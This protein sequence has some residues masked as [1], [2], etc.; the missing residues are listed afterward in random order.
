M[1]HIADNVKVGITWCPL[2]KLPAW[3]ILTGSPD[4]VG[5]AAAEFE[6]L[7]P[8]SGEVEGVSSPASSSC[9]RDR[10]P[11]MPHPMR[12]RRHILGRMVPHALL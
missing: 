1:M 8:A 9:S 4:L 12:P 3:G 10:V 6:P 2:M 7:P 5:S 11:A